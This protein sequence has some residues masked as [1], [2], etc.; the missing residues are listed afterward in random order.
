MKKTRVLPLIVKALNCA[1]SKSPH[2][3]KFHDYKAKKVATTAI[4][5][6]KIRG[7]A[8][9]LAPPVDAVGLG[10]EPPDVAAA[11]VAAVVEASVELASL[12]RATLMSWGIIKGVEPAAPRSTPLLV[13]TSGLAAKK[14]R[15]Y[16]K[17][18]IRVRKK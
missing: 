8:S 9:E 15:V 6:I 17:M 10:A 7:D 13:M 4:A 14:V 18:I 16:L 11:D 12:E 2:T 5:A 1:C 3:P